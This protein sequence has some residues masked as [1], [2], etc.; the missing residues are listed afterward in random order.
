M[1]ENRF[2]VGQIVRVVDSPSLWAEKIKFVRVYGLHEQA[3]R[4]FVETLNGKKLGK[5]GTGY[6]SRRFMAV[7]PVVEA[8]MKAQASS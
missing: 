6:W 1:R 7:E 5:K 8:I 4:V 2:T 3:E